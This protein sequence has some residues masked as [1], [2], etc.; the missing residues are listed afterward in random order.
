MRMNSINFRK[1]SLVIGIAFTCAEILACQ[2]PGIAGKPTKPTV[3]VVAH[4][5]NLVAVWR[6]ARRIGEEGLVSEPNDPLLI[7]FFDDGTFKAVFTSHRFETYHDFWGEW[8]TEGDSLALTITGGNNLPSQS[9]YR[10][11]YEVRES[12]LI[13]HG[14]VLVDDFAG[15]MTAFSYERPAPDG[16]VI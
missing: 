5:P 3:E 12:E 15:P 4:N 11:Q 1:L 16:K 10:G 14:I 9:T 2:I 13:L 8:S 7:G 6:E